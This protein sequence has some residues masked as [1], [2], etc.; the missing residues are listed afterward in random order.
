MSDLLYVLKSGFVY[1]EGQPFTLPDLFKYQIEGQSP[2]SGSR[3][4][5]VVVVPDAKALR[6]KAITIMWRD[7]K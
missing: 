3:Y 2:N 7:E 4:L 5:R 6:I 1:E